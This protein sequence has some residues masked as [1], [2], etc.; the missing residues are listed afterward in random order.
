M[1]WFCLFSIENCRRQHRHWSYV[2]SLCNCICAHSVSVVHSVWFYFIFS[3]FKSSFLSFLKIW[4]FLLNYVVPNRDNTIIHTLYHGVDF[5]LKKVW[6]FEQEIQVLIGSPVSS[7][8]T[9]FSR[10]LAKKRDTHLWVEL[11]VLCSV[12]GYKYERMA[13]SS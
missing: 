5:G 10:Y 1:S 8:Q 4:K 9:F 11:E 2:E 3:A 12:C 13:N 6:I 7:V